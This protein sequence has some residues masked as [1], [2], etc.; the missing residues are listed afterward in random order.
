MAPADV[1]PVSTSPVGGG[2]AVQDAAPG[3][4]PFVET[5]GIHRAM[6]RSAIRE[7]SVGNPPWAHG[8]AQM[9]A[10]TRSRPNRDPVLTH[11]RAHG[12]RHVHTAALRRA[13]GLPSVLLRS[14]FGAP[15]APFPA[16][17]R[18]VP[19]FRRDRAGFPPVPRRSLPPMRTTSVMGARPIG[20][21]GV[22]L[23]TVESAVPPRF[24][25][26]RCPR[27]SAAVS[28]SRT[29][30][31]GIRDGRGREGAGRA[32]RRIPGHAPDCSVLLSLNRRGC[33]RTW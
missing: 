4:I 17:S 11:Q 13:F 20:P 32:A 18:R 15:G 25:P 24:A 3:A 23:G 31:L 12:A 30:P 27:A 22:P 28:V 19:G 29:A 5:R 9:E 2:P 8:A 33:V 6:R 7:Q 1:L 10:L 16:V 14:R 26:A 21:A